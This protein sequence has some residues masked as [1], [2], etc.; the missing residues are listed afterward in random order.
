MTR[1]GWDF[2][3]VPLRSAVLDNGGPA[4]DLIVATDGDVDAAALA[5]SLAPLGVDIA[6]ESLLSSHPLYW[7]RV[8]AGSPVSREEL[9]KRVELSGARV[10]Y[11]ASARH[12]SLALGPALDFEHA[13][14][15]CP[16]EWP[17]R[18]RSEI[19]EPSTPGRWFLGEN[20]VDVQRRYCE[21]GAN[22]RL[23]IIDNDGLDSERVDLDAEVLIAVSDPPR[24]S[25]HGAL[26]AGWAVG[27]YPSATGGPFLSG[28]APAAS[29]R[30]Y[31]IPK[32]GSEVIALPLAIA[33]AVDDGADVIV[34]ATYVEGQTSPMLDDAFAFARR[35]GRG[36][37]G[38]AIV[39]PTGRQASSPSGSTHASFSLSLG[40]PAADTRAFCVGPSGADGRWFLWCDRR[41]KY[42]PFANRGPSVRWLAPGDDMASP[43]ATPECVTHA[44]SSGAAAVAA[45]VILLVLGR[46]PRLEL[47]EL[48][49]IVTRTISTVDGV[50][51]LRAPAVADAYD[52]HPEARDAD[53]HDAKHGYGRIHA[54]RACLAATDPF[55]SALV[56]MGEEDAA[57]R[58]ADLRSREPLARAAYSA[59]LACRAA[60]S[61]A[62]DE[63]LAFSVRVIA[64]HARLTANRAEH[65]RSHPRGALLRE[66]SVFMRNL[67][68]WLRRSTAD[69]EVAC[70]LRRAIE[71][72]GTLSNAEIEAFE[73]AIYAL[74]DS[75][76]AAPSIGSLHAERILAAPELR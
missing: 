42:R 59:K 39:L 6:V 31:L 57:K 38:T 7:T 56:M 54:T 46:N 53:G 15:R 63:S 51:R 41:G 2:S 36:A 5:G 50:E 74:A 65:Q 4:T 3:Y 10:R 13:R 20:G 70:E 55:A 30:L 9:G 1:P 26:L 17:A 66:L 8:C 22:T 14:P 73:G 67:A 34:C 23:A 61:L 24:G 47:A 29:A 60:A 71:R 32:P 52:L 69:A 72:L 33:R 28:V 27:A 75:L 49:A 12:G 76:W 48:E 62:S 18:S 44:E 58:W 45:G 43:L 16:R 64:R 21:N 11:V 68:I 37:R 35:L 40:D 25:Q 19:V